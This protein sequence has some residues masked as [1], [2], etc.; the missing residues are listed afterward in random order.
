[1]PSVSAY[2]TFASSSSCLSAQVIFL[3][4]TSGEGGD[5]R[6][7]IGTTADLSP[8]PEF[9]DFASPAQCRRRLSAEG[10]GEKAIERVVA[11]TI[12]K[13]SGNTGWLVSRQRG[14]ASPVGLDY[15]I[16]DGHVGGYVDDDA[17]CVRVCA[18]RAVFDASFDSLPGERSPSRSPS[19]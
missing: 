14:A 10:L 8:D 7:A 1:M 15:R 17:L 18:P 12:F 11:T 4:R 13:R 2:S 3:Y 6:W 5:G 19:R 16:A 9:N